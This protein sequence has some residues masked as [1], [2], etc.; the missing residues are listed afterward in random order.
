VPVCVRLEGRK[1]PLCTT[2]DSP[3]LSVPVPGR[4]PRWIHP[5]AGATGYY[6]WLLPA[7]GLDALLASGWATLSRA[8]RISAA[9][10]VVNAAR[11]AALP[12]DRALALLPRFTRDDEPG[13]VASAASLLDHAWSHWTDPEDKPLLE[14]RMRALLRPPLDRIGF[15]PRAGEPTRQ[16]RLRQSLVQTLALHAG[17]RQV[18]SRAAGLGRPGSAP[19]AAFIPTP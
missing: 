8:E 12:A 14:A 17:D 1:A 4:C 5:N 19:T 6:R 15:A 10:A 2:L 18:L 7:A 11:D 13:V 9:N 16:A 3:S